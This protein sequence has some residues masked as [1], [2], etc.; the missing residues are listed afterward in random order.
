MVQVW[1][2]DLE[3]SAAPLE[4][5]EI[6]TPRLSDDDQARIEALNHATLRR[7]R[8][9]TTI[10]LRVLIAAHAG[11]PEFDRVPFHRL[12]GG[13][14][15]FQGAR[16]SFSVA[17]SGQRA[18]LALGRDV[19]IG[20]DL[21]VLRT[22]HMPKDRQ[23]ALVRAALVFG[24]LPPDEI[25]AGKSDEETLVLR[26]WVRLEALAKAHGCGIARVLAACGVLARGASAAEDGPAFPANLGESQ[27][28]HVL[29]VFDLAL[30]QD[31]AG[32]PWFAA[33]AVLGAPGEGGGGNSGQEVC[34]PEVRLL[35]TSRSGLV[36]V[37]AGA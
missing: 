20:V 14:P 34:T 30:P 4:A 31:A 18:L 23:Q 5:L 15:V 8:R 21:E 36:K 37:L 22:L 35:P 9:L 33:L 1:L 12:K 10:A 28:E 13:K 17:H 3:R 2:V 11:G 32:Q 24:P 19:P 27:D 6:E 26:S 25:L 29:R 7:Q 16:L